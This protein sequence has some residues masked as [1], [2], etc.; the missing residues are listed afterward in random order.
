MSLVLSRFSFLAIGAVYHAH[1]SIYAVE[2][3]ENSPAVGALV[4]VDTTTGNVSYTGGTGSYNALSALSATGDLSAIDSEAGLFYF[5]GDT[6]GGTTLVAVSLESGLEVCSSQVTGIEEVGL[7]GLGQSFDFDVL[8]RTLVLSGFSSTN[9]S[10]HI[11]YRTKS[12]STQIS[13][14]TCDITFDK[15]ET[16]GLVED[17]PILHASAIDSEGQRLFLQLDSNDGTAKISEIP[18][19]G[20][21]MTLYPQ[22]GLPSHLFYGMHWDQETGRIFGVCPGKSAGALELHSLS[23]STGK[24]SSSEIQNVPSSW[25]TLYGNEGDMSTFDEHG[26]TIFFVAGNNANAAKFLAQVNIDTSALEDYPVL[27]GDLGLGSFI[28]MEF[29]H[30]G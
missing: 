27:S 16:F 17:T 2:L 22:G 5:L 14:R 15:I 1:A 3:V 26:R 20:G 13:E 30:V 8:N 19:A 9:Q 18:L 10:E 29:T 23:P 24:W 21:P 12:I 28:N 7:V 11:L 6:A 25:N 4:E